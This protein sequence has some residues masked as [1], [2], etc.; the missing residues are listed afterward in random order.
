V[1]DGGYLRVPEELGLG[2]ELAEDV[3]ARYRVA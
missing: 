2:V 1:P 3:V